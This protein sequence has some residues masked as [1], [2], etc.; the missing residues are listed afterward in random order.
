MDEF[1][2]IAKIR[3]KLAEKNDR[4]RVGIGDDAAVLVPPK[5]NL[6]TTTDCLVESVHFDLKFSS[7]EELGQKA[8]AVNLSDIAAMGGTPLYALVSLGIRNGISEEF[9]LNMYDGIKRMA[10]RFQVAVVGGN[11]TQSPGHFFVDITVIGEAESYWTRSGA[12]E[13]DR[14]AVT[15]RLGGSACGLRLLQEKGT[16]VRN[17]FADL[18]DSHLA[19]IPCLR[20]AK[21][22]M[23][24]DAVTSAIDISDGLSSELHHLA[25]S[26]DLGFEIEAAKIP[27]ASKL[28][29]ACKLLGADPM[30]FALHG[31]EEYQLLLTMKPEKWEESLEVLRKAG[32]ELTEIGKCTSLTRSVILVDSLGKKLPLQ[33][34]GWNHLNYS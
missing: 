17:Q 33:P 26:S 15:G 20:E 7:P 23:G 19:P 6:L 18:V 31:G 21:L 16:G 8:L 3:D 27:F 5:G 34:K 22:L 25:Q 13:G 24:L 1:S 30:E 11:I 28:K 32:A 29:E 2:L 14:V 9:I 10:D 12:R 4:V